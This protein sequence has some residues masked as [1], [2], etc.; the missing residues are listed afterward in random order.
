MGIACSYSSQVYH[1][2]GTNTINETDF[3]ITD[4]NETLSDISDEE[5]INIIDYRN[6]PSYKKNN[7]LNIYPYRRFRS[8][9]F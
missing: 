7:N 9:S 1:Y 3:N 5:N 8:H 4:F 6:P 2:R